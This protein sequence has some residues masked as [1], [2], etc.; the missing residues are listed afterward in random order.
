[1]KKFE[2]ILRRNYKKTAFVLGLLSALAFP[3]AYLFVLFLLAFALSYIVADKL[4]STKKVCLFG[5]WFGFAHFMAGF[6]WIANALLVDVA[7]FGWL[8][9]IT[10]LCIG[11]FF[12]LFAV[13]SFAVWQFLQ[14]KNKWLKVFAFSYT[15]VLFEWIRSFLFTGFPWNM[16]GTVLAFS[17]TLIQTA[18]IWGTYGLSFIV[19][20]V[21]GCV[22]IAATG[23]KF[24]SL[25][26][27]SF[28]V[29]F[30]TIF[31]LCRIQGYAYNESDIK[32]RLVQPSISQNM[33]WNRD[34]LENNFFEYVN[35][36]K[37]SELNDVDFVVWGETALPFDVEQVTEY[38]TY[39]KQAIPDSGYLITGVVRFGIDSGFY[40][41]YNSMYIINK[42]ADVIQ[43]YDKNHLV[44]FGEYIPFRKYLPA[45]I[46]PIANNVADF[47]TSE[48]L[49]NIKIKDYPV[50]GALICYEII[51][52]DNVVNKKEKPQWLV[53]LT[54]D[55]WYGKSSGPYQHLVAAQMRAIE[56]GITVVRSANSG[57]SAVISPTGNILKQL[58]LHKK[59]YIDVALPENMSVDTIYTHIGGIG[60]ICILSLVMLFLACFY[61]FITKHKIV[62]D[63]KN[64]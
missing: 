26:V 16:L 21:A 54:N 43:L 18:S 17:D 7:A 15:W 25:C 39:L 14:N 59:A 50:F 55:G 41:P 63:K 53:V 46:R 45:W 28:I 29:V 62:V 34:E 49:K 27:L 13:P 30:I 11:G 56:E 8:Y 48:K 24:A 52:P 22:Y 57:I 35:L 61:V 60:V 23:R 10:L 32:V 40:K 6:Y 4:E 37:K 38:K 31:G 44:P 20:I 5:Y 58:D 3:P 12:G 33:K 36:S 42:N 2:E 51:F 19:L 1:M 47:A 9:P 64:I